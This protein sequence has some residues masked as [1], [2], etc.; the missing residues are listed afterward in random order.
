MVKF[1]ANFEAKWYQCQ[2]KHSEKEKEMKL[3]YL[4]LKSLDMDPSILTMLTKYRKYVILQIS[5]KSLK[6]AA[7]IMWF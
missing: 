5:L 7:M 4:L 1:A 3:V 2:V 6:M